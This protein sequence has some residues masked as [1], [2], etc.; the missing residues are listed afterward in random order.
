RPEVLEPALSARPG[1][2][3]QAIAFPLPDEGCRRKLFEV[4][5]R[6]LD[7]SGVEVTR[8]VAQTDGVSPAFIEELLRKAVLMAAE[9]GEPNNPLRLQ[10][11]D[12]QD[13]MRELIYFGGELTQK[14]LGYR[15]S[16][17]GYQ[18]IAVGQGK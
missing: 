2:I 1:R 8:W 18:S 9:R 14:L 10:E 12:I 4:Y 5:G 16:R 11:S 17:I 6:K 13:A 15:P 7:L 3:D